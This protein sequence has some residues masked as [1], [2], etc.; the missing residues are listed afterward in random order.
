VWRRYSVAMASRMFTR[1]SAV[2]IP[3]SKPATL[4]NR[5]SFESYGFSLVGSE[6]RVRVV[7]RRR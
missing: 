7:E 6:G 1:S 5:N 4:W 2:S 3:G